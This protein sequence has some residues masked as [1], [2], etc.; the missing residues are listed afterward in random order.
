MSSDNIKIFK[1]PA[2]LSQRL[3]EEFIQYV[4]KKEKVNISLAGGST[5]KIFYTTLSEPKY[6][7]Q[8]DWSKIHFYWGDERCVSPDNAESNFLM[9]K[10]SLLDHIPIP[11]ENIHR[12]LGENNPESELIRYSDEIV[13]N[14]PIKKGIPKFDWVFLGLGND[15]HTASLFPNTKELENRKDICVITTHPETGQKRISFSYP[16]LENA[17]RISF[18]VTNIAKA[19]MI[20]TIIEERSVDTKYPAS[21]LYN[22]RKDCEWW[23][24]EDAAK[25]LDAKK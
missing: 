24:D 11:K 20:R 17:A 15:G 7:N 22:K 21:L 3:A 8:I 9:T 16:L 12:I 5:P 19:E 10:T 14:L 4:D 13:H 1:N 2:E 6:K 23:L 18:L 25:N